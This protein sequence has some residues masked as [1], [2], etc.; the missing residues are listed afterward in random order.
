MNTLNPFN[1]ISHPLHQDI[2]HFT[3]PAELNIMGHNVLWVERLGN[4]NIL[5]NTVVT[6]PKLTLLSNTSIH[7]VELHNLEVFPIKRLVSLSYFAIKLRIQVGSFIFFVSCLVT[8]I[9]G[10]PLFFVGNHILPIYA[11]TNGSR[12]VSTLSTASRYPTKSW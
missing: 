8:K 10:W 9:V 1:T 7:H 2:P 6:I 12:R 5:Q 4:S 11:L 3:S